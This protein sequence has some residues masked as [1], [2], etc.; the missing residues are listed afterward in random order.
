[1]S[2]KSLVRS[3]FP[4]PVSE[5]LGYYVYRLVDPRDGRTFYVGKG[6][7]NRLFHHVAEAT[8]LAERTSLKLETI[9]DVE[10][11]GQK[12]RYIIHRHGLTEAEALLVESALIDAYEELSNAQLGHGTHTNGLTTVDDI[13]ALYD[14]GSVGIDVPAVLLNLNKQYDRALTPEQLY[15]RTRGY[16]V[17]RPDRHAT[18]KY[19]M[20]H[21]YGII[22]EVYRI[23]SWEKSPVED[24]EVSGLRRFDTVVSKSRF[25][26][27]FTGSV[28]TD[29]R[30]KYVGKSI[31]SSSQNPVRW[32][33]C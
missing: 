15:E 3:F 12:V 2:D 18:V 28:A 17:M 30:D 4:E 8:E 20:A 25:R 22:R 19:A 32:M 24:I 10:I 9:R 7:G 16:W 21:A 33:N 31:S 26:W 23:E 27:T 11:S 1:M 6:R 13:F 5:A 14:A 29:V